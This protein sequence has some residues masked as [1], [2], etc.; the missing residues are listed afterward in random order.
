MNIE[1][2]GISI[3]YQIDGPEGAP[4]LVF[5]NS[6]ATDLSLWDAQVRYF[7]DTYR[8]LRY[9]QRGHGATQAPPGPYAFETLL[10]DAIGLMDALGV[11]TAPFCGLSMGGATAMGLALRHPERI[12]R[13][14]VC[15]AP[16]AS[17]PLSAQQWQ[18][19]IVIA[20]ERGMA[21]LAE[22]TLAR[23]FPAETL[24]AN[25]PHVANVRD[26]ILATPVEGFIGCAAALADHDYR[27]AAATVRRRVLLLVGERDGVI[28]DAM[29][30]MGAELPG[31]WLIELPGAGHLS[32]LDRPE[33]FNRALN[34]FLRA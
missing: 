17:S 12:E 18:E 14:I 16:C 28:P 27:T 6:L 22:P 15:D 8:I 29:R 24:S 4:W 23:W 1:A 30:R 7:R 9:D 21:A 11:A 2:N 26:M 13:A 19:R 33:L 25:P 34:T 31:S 10:D 20:R 5:S 32:N 3:H